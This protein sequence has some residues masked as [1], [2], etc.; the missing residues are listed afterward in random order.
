MLKYYC[1]R[2]FTNTTKHS[3]QIDWDTSLM[4]TNC[5]TFFCEQLLDWSS[6][7]YQRLSRLGSPTSFFRWVRLPRLTC[8]HAVTKFELPSSA[9]R[10]PDIE[11]LANSTIPKFYHSAIWILDPCFHLICTHPGGV[12][13]LSGTFNYSGNWNKEYWVQFRSALLNIFQGQMMRLQLISSYVK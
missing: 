11:N 5:L 10:L 13:I 12:L 9:L 4:F 6:Y 3:C 8:C 7:T 2:W 1:F